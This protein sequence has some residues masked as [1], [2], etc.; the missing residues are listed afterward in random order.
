MKTNFEP[1]KKKDKKFKYTEEEVPQK[2]KD[3]KKNKHTIP[4][5]DQMTCNWDY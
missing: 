2:K 5:Y 1:I 4:I 3:K